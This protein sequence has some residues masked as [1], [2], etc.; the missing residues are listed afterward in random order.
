M[1]FFRT[2]DKRQDRSIGDGAR[3]RRRLQLQM[4][5]QMQAAHEAAA[6]VRVAPDATVGA[7]A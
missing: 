5:Q 4:Q 3:A 7:D 1:V 6:N 2:S